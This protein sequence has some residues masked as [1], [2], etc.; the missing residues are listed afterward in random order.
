MPK[1]D[2]FDDPNAPE[3]NSIVPAVVAAVF[4]DA[5]E[6]LVIHRTDNDMWALPGGAQDLGESLPQA[7]QRE[8]LEETGIEV[9]VVDI[10]GTY[11]DPRHIIAY[12]DGEVRQEFSISFRARPIGGEPRPSDES[13]E[14]KWITPD[15]LE[16]LDMSSAMRLRVEHAL[17]QD[18]TTVYIG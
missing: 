3:P 15:Q 17:D 2:Y 18:R 8:V 5:G 7:V 1:R 12:D 6:L 13:S 4:N 11:S 16:H 10:I 14:V 9:E